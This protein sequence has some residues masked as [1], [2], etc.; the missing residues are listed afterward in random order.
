MCNSAQATGPSGRPPVG[1]RVVIVG[2]GI[3]GC[4]L[5]DELTARGWTRVTVLDQ[6]EPGRTGG[7]TSHAPGLV[8]QTSGDRSLTRFARATTAK[9]GALRGEGRPCFRPV[10][11]LEVAATRERLSDLHRRH[12]WATAAGIESHLLRPAPWGAPHPPL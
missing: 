6:G 10:G 3:V 11:G 9:Y 5:A 2:A 7:A 8:F 4:A 12:G 1:P